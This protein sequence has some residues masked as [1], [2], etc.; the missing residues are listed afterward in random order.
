VSYRFQVQTLF[1]LHIDPAFRSAFQQD[2]RA[3][4][5]GL[6]EFELRELSKLPESR[7]PATDDTDLAQWAFVRTGIHARC[8]VAMPR[9][10]STLLAIAAAQGEI[11]EV[12]LLRSTDLWRPVPPEYDRDEVPPNPYVYW[13]ETARVLQMANRVFWQFLSYALTVHA[14]EPRRSPWLPD[15]AR[16]E[17]D[18]L[19]RRVALYKRYVPPGPTPLAMSPE[20]RPRLSAYAECGFYGYDVFKSEPAARPVG[21]VFLYNGD[22]LRVLA[23][24]AETAPVLAQ[25]DGQ[26]RLGDCSDRTRA[27]L[28]GL[29]TA[30]ALTVGC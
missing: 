11:L 3:A 21:V 22:R 13:T 8:R 23:V 17:Y 14:R 5:P 25:L 15:V 26:V 9:T 29:A 12:D 19:A 20:S 30:G 28:A 1:K 6:S 2:P 10:Y 16:F 24:D 4:A 27:V 18:T 7:R